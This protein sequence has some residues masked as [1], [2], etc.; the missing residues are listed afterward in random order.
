[1]TATHKI[2]W[3]SLLLL[4]AAYTMF[5]NFLSIV[6]VSWAI[7]AIAIIWVLLLAAFFMAPLEQIRNIV[8]RWLQTDAIT[9]VLL[10]ITAAL[11]SF[12]FLWWNIF[13]YL[14][15]IVGA[16]ALARLDIQTSRFTA[17]DAFYIL[18]TTSLMGIGLGWMIHQWSLM[19][20]L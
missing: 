16:E 2:P 4:L 12:V 14:V 7:W 1:M 17:S 11:A 13:L 8:G 15:A 18:T 5:G 3:I 9:F 19:L 10:I 20:R 6:S